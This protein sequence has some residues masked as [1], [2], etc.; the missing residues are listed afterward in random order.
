MVWDSI[1]RTTTP[2][3][4]ISLYWLSCS[5]FTEVQPRKTNFIPNS[6]EHFPW[7]GNGEKGCQVFNEYNKSLNG[8][9]R[10]VFHRDKS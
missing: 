4:F 8:N 3:K 1:P 10:H 9:T 2:K 7:E 5:H 6:A